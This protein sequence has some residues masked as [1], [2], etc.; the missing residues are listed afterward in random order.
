MVSR[1]LTHTI[2]RVVPLVYKAIKI[3]STAELDIKNVLEVINNAFGLTNAKP[4]D[5]DTKNLTTLHVLVLVSKSFADSIHFVP[6]SCCNDFH[7]SSV[8]F[9]IKGSEIATIAEFVLSSCSRSVFGI[10]NPR[11]C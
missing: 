10:A 9:C 7:E 8:E 1:A 2:E 11:K 5:D 4:I 3:T 6:N